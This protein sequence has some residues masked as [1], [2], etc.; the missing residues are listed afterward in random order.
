[1]AATSAMK[2]GIGGRRYRNTGTYGSPTWAAQLLDLN[3]T[4]SL[5]WDWH[6]AGS[7]ETRAKLYMK[8][9]ADLQIGVKSRSDD[10]EVGAVAILAAAMSPTVVLDSLV[11]NGLITVEGASGFRAEFLVNLTG[12]PQEADGSIYHDYELKPTWTANGYPRTVV[13]GAASAPTFITL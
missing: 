4:A 2:P 11:L 8:G 10:A 13:M 5:P 1:M 3:V 7:R 9:R 12:E 6:E